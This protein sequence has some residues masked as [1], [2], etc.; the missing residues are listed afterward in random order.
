MAAS[1]LSLCVV[2][3]VIGVVVAVW[4]VWVVVVAVGIVG[5]VVAVGLDDRRISSEFAGPVVARQK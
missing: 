1:R 2:A 3:G 4:V 5:V